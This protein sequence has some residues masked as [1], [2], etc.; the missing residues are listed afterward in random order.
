M[1]N[2]LKIRRLAENLRNAIDM[3]VD[4]KELTIHPFNK[5]PNDCCDMTSELLSHYLTEHNI[6]NQLVIGAHKKDSQW[7]HVWVQ[8]IDGIVVDITGDQFD[9]KSNMSGNACRVYVGKEGD[10]HKMFCENRQFEPPTNFKESTYDSLGI[11][12]RRESDLIKAYDIIERYL[13][14][15]EMKDG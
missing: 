3:A 10:V 11:P 9:G 12:N 13:Y 5:F 1:K 6:E 14:A 15:G 8:T 7:H 4:N 2:Y